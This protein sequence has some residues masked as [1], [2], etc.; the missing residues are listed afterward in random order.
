MPFPRL[1]HPRRLVSATIFQATPFIR[2]MHRSS[3]QR[4]SLPATTRRGLGRTS[5]HPAKRFDSFFLSLSLSLSNVT[6]PLEWNRGA[7]FENVGVYVVE[8]NFSREAIKGI[9]S[10]VFS[11]WTTRVKGS[12]LS[13]YF[14]AQ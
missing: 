9:L 2:A 8:I 3:T 1:V 12:I 5:K 13:G 14:D 11:T 6:S 4:A 7:R 10:N